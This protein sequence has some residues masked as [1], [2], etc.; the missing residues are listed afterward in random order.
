MYQ[1]LGTIILFTAGWLEL[2]EWTMT[3]SEFKVTTS[4]KSSRTY[5]VVI[6]FH[7]LCMF[8]LKMYVN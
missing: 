8:F 3:H 6:D 5:A 7:V 4:G 2:Q 1:I